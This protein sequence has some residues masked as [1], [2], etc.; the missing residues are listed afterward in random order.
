MLF[1]VEKVNC[2]I[3]DNFGAGVSLFFVNDEYQS[4]NQL[5]W[6]EFDSSSRLTKHKLRGFVRTDL[7][8][9]TCEKTPPFTPESQSLI[10]TTYG[11]RVLGIFGAP[12]G[13]QRI[14]TL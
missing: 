14:M 12:K 5:V 13:Q 2:T 11:L 7:V 10:F 6:R 9:A 4:I 8:L 1:E 3:F